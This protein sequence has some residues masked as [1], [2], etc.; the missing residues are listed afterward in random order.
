VDVKEVAAKAEKLFS[1]YEHFDSEA[2]QAALIG[3]FRGVAA[4]KVTVGQGWLAEF[5]LHG[6]SRPFNKEQ[7]AVISEIFESGMC[8][9]GQQLAN[10]KAKGF[11]EREGR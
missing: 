8:C 9:E 3:H 11:A 5:L 6:P 1:R 2:G 7:G 4:S 10:E